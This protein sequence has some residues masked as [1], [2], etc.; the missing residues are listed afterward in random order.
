[1]NCSEA[2]ELLLR[3]DDPRLERCGSPELTEHLTSCPACRSTAAEIAQLEDTWRAQPLPAEADRARL[4]FL[5]RLPRVAT[6]P[7]S[8]PR[9]YI[10]PRWIAAAVL[11][12]GIGIAGWFLFS[13][14][15]AQ[16]APA[17]I[18]RL[19][20]WNVELAEA[21]PAERERLYAAK[22]PALAEAVRSTSLGESD[23]ELAGMLLD[24]GTWLAQNDDPVAAAE[25]FSAVADKLVDHMQSASDRKD[26]KLANR[27]AKLQ[28]Q[29]LQ[30]GIGENLARA[31]E[32]GTL[33]FDNKRKLEKLVLRDKDRMKKLL[34]LLEKN[35]DISRKEL[36]KA[37][38]IPPK[39]P[40]STT[41]KA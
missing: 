23:R 1:M 27:Y 16:A 36:R 22:Q 26:T 25:R 40:K 9:R 31:E 8:K 12:F 32:S 38:D 15:E 17:L 7:A 13:G 20:D 6:P 10:F 18:E 24:N 28:A 5:K 19:V 37:L 2:K 3:A 11:L 39:H 41:K 14:S 21:P 34:D 33:N 35:P 29:V 4:A 30:R